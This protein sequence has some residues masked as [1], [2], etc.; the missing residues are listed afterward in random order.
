MKVYVEEVI[1]GRVYWWKIESRCRGGNK[2]DVIGTVAVG[3][4][5]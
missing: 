1:D 2:N 3:G 5:L 4:Q